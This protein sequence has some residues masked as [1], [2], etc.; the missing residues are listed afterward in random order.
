[1]P[2]GRR[3]ETRGWV[4]LVFLPST[5]GGLIP[6]G[7]K[8]ERGMLDFPWLA[9][10]LRE[11][12][13]SRRSTFLAW[14]SARVSSPVV[15]ELYWGWVTLSGPIDSCFG[16]SCVSAPCLTAYGFSRVFYWRIQDFGSFSGNLDDVLEVSIGWGLVNQPN[17][18]L[19]NRLK[20][21]PE[22][23]KR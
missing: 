15:L 8:K 7:G 4:L 3:R 19:F 18:K 14:L 12:F 9:V 16:A 20:R 23:P 2:G 5:P 10:E 21:E 17:C 11:W 1:M 13:A 22:R 6:R